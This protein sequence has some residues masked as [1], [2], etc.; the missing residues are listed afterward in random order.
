M[1]LTYRVRARNTSAESENKIHD[2]TVAASYGYRGGL[3]PGIAVYAYMTV[4]IV[5]RFGLDYESLRAARPDLVM[6]SLSAA[7]QDGPWRQLVN[8]GSMST[9]LVGLDGLQGYAGEPP[10]SA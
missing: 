4:P 3:V 7:G 2:D 9:C 10:M 5:E 6:I 1:L 8:F